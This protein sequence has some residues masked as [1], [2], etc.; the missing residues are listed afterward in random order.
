MQAAYN[1]YLYRKGVK[2]PIYKKALNDLASGLSW[3]I[4]TVIVLRCF[5][6]ISSE[7]TQ[8]SLGLILLVIY[9][10]LVFISGG[11]VLISRGAK[12]LQMIEEV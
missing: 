11:Y 5:E 12:K 6:S 8:L 1:L 3:I 4:I 9:V 2:G 7:L 10:L